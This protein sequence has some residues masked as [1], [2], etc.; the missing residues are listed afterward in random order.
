MKTFVRKENNK[1]YQFDTRFTVL[2][3]I[4]DDSEIVVSKNTIIQRRV[5][6]AAL[7]EYSKNWQED[8]LGRVHFD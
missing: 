8:V 3:Q 2:W 4:F 1:K 7:K 6:G 5:L